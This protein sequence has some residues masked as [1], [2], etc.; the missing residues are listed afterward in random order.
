MTLQ[1]LWQ[2]IPESYKLL[3]EAFVILI[4]ALGVGYWLK[5]KFK[6]RMG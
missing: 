4:V 6:K 5:K 2:N 1:T 3:L